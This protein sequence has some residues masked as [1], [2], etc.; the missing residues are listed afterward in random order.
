MDSSYI[1]NGLQ[2]ALDSVTDKIKLVN[3]LIKVSPDQTGF[4]NIVS[5]VNDGVVATAL[6][7][8]TILFLMSLVK[9]SLDDKSDDY[10]KLII[11]WFMRII[12]TKGL[13]ENSA[14]IMMEIYKL[15][16]KACNGITANVTGL[17]N[18]KVEIPDKPEG[19]L[20]VLAALPKYKGIELGIWFA[21]VII[22]VIVLGVMIDVC[23][24]TMFSPIAF[25]FFA[26]DGVDSIKN[27]LKNYLSLCL[28]GAYIM[29][30]LTLFEVL[31]TS[32]ILANYTSDSYFGE[33]GL[34]IIYILVLIK[35]L[36]SSGRK[37]K[38][39]LGM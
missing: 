37:T 16:V 28:Q 19:T 5:Q 1:T 7:I 6:S 34:Y 11:K 9:E 17:S 21:G 39:I 13:I 38:E 3:D 32:N 4:W 12:I 25:A 18:I 24:C 22:I 15:G 35:I 30:S 20:Q 33:L 36:I 31:L 23:L 10:L 27:F 26:Y 8:A 29:G 2:S 14:N